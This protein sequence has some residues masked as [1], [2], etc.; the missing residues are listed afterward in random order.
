MFI[1]DIYCFF[2]GVYG[3]CIFRPLFEEICSKIQQKNGF[4][5]FALKRWSSVLFP[6]NSFFSQKPT[7]TYE[8]LWITSI[9]RSFWV[10][11]CKT[12]IRN[13]NSVVCVRQDK[14]LL[15]NTSLLVTIYNL[16]TFGCEQRGCISRGECTLYRVITYPVA[17]VSLWI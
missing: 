17:L 2:H 16:N 13:S 14:K 9:F 10:I 11:G 8:K 12:D 1:G 15:D 5:E 7:F 6:K 4:F 3:C